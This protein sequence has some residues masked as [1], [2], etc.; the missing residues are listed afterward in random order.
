MIV[1]KTKKGYSV[2]VNGFDNVQNK[3]IAEIKGFGKLTAYHPEVLFKNISRTNKDGSIDLIIDP[4]AANE[5][6]TGIL[7]KRAYMA[8]RIKKENGESNS[9]KWQYIE[10]V[11]LLESDIVKHFYETLSISDVEEILEMIKK[12]NIHYLDNMEVL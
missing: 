8:L 6:D 7:P 9:K 3:K 1:F 10:T 2:P 4:S 12:K 5:L 11:R